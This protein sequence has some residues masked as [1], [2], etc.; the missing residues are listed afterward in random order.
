[1]C[2]IAGFSGKGDKNILLNMMRTLNHRGPDDEGIYADD[3]VHLGHKRLSII[4]LSEKG[5]QPMTN[6]NGSVWLVFNGE[7][8][9]FQSLRKSLLDKDHRFASNTDSEVIIHLYEDLGTEMFKELNGMFA[10]ALWDKRLRKLFLVRDRMGQKPLYYSFADQTLIFASE[11]NALLEHPLVE[12]KLDMGSLAKFLFYEHVPTPDCIWENVS[13]LNPGSYLEYEPLNRSYKVRQYWKISFLPRLYLKDEEYVE[14]LEEK[15]IQSVKS[16]LV[17]DVPVGVYLSGGM[18]SATVAY[19]SQKVLNGKLKTFT[20][21]FKEK[22][23]DEQD[24]ARE[25]ARMLGTEHH[26]VDFNEQDFI[27]TTLEIIPML[28]E[29]FSDSSLI[30][31]YFLNRFARNYIK[32][33]LGGEGGDEIFVGYPIFRAHELL[34]YLRAIPGAIRRN[35]VIPFINAIPS[36]H[37]NE[38]WEYKLKKFIEAEGYLNNPYYCQQIWLGAFGPSYLVKLFKKEFHD[39]ISLNSLFDNIDIYRK[40]ADEREE[41]SDGIMRQ[42]QHKYLMDDGMTKTDR[43]SMANSLE[44]RAP[45]L[46]GDIVDWVNRIPFECKYRGG[47]TKILLRRLMQDKLPESILSGPKRGFTPPIAEWFARHFQKEVKEY[48]F[49]RNE[50]FDTGYIEKL[51]KEHITNKQNHRKILWTLFVWKLWSSRN[52]QQNI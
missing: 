15:L 34:K 52:I 41:L 20:V 3:R 11:A 40:D 51:W 49:A 23:F 39:A 35:I 29:P 44:M 26:E 27:K 33:A 42:T 9:N 6:E 16:H 31:A 30:P 48:I 47:K 13:K 5:R 17:A 22:T 2:G 21:A 36:S 37:S 32:V 19:Y 10:F 7:I 28:D 8:Y 46:D 1:M 43:A 12:K 25:T 50:F 38:T 24:R 18:D 45:L 14:V 4:D